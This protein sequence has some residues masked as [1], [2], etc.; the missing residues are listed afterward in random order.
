MVNGVIRFVFDVCLDYIY[1][2]YFVRIRE[3]FIGKFGFFDYFLVIILR[4][5]KIMDV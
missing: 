5:Y 4:C 2:S 1:F 3:V